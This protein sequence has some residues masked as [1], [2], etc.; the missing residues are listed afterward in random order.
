MEKRVDAGLLLSFYGAMLTERQQQMLQL[1]YED[2][3]SLSEIAALLGVSRQGVHDAV[4]RGE[5]QLF[6]LE[7]RL[8]LRARWVRMCDGLTACRMAL[9]EQ[10]TDTAITII[11]ELLREEE[12]QDGI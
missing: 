4:R 2:D 10:R 6:A 12:G 1:Y 3:L 5:Q 8:G 7:E 11:D 9:I